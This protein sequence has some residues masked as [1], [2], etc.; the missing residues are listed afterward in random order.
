VPTPVRLALAL[1]STTGLG[2]LASRV[3]FVDAPHGRAAAALGVGLG[4]LLG[5]GA[6]ALP[7]V[8]IGV[9]LVGL[10]LGQAWIDAAGFALLS[11][12]ALW[13]V[14]RFLRPLTEAPALLASESDVGR[15]VLGLMVLFPVLAAIAAWL[16]ALSMGD[17][18][19]GMHGF[20]ETLA[21][22]A[23]SSALL[24]PWPPLLLRQARVRPPAS[25]VSAALV[26]LLLALPV[27]FARPEG[28]LQR[29]WFVTFLPFAWLAYRHG[30]LGGLFASLVLG[31]V[32]AV[33][34]QQ[35]LG[36]FAGMGQDVSLVLAAFA[37]VICSVSALM[38]VNLRTERLS[39]LAARAEASRRLA[40]AYRLARF[41]TWEHD[42][43]GDAWWWSDESFH[44]LGL[45]PKD[46]G[47]SRDLYL[48][49]LHPDD[50][51]RAFEAGRA[52]IHEGAPYDLEI[53]VV[54]KTGSIRWIHLVGEVL[55]DESGKPH[56]FA[57]AVQDV[58]RRHEESARA[59]SSQK[60]DALGTL[61]AG[62][63][64]D[65]NNI[66]LA[67]RSH[68][69]LLSQSLVGQR[70]T[71]DSL[72]QILSSTERASRLVQQILTFGRGEDVAQ[73]GVV[74]ARDPLR[75]SADFLRA[76]LPTTV[77]LRTR[78]PAA[79]L[80]VRADA[81]Q[82]ERVIVNLVTNAYQAG[83]DNVAIDIHA[84]SVDVEPAAGLVAGIAPGHY[85]MIEVTDTGPGVPRDV[86]DR[87]FEPFFT[88]KPV[89]EGTGLGL[90]VV[91]GIIEAHGGRILVKS[92]HGDGTTFEIYLPS[93]EGDH[94]REERAATEVSAR[95]DE[96]VLLVDDEVAVTRGTRR[97][98][99]R[100]GYKVEV[101]QDG[102]SALAL[103]LDDP[104][105]FDVVVTD[106]SM[107]GLTGTELARTLRKVRPELPII[108]TTGFDAS[109]TV[110]VEEDLFAVVLIKPFGGQELGAA[111]R[112]SVDAERERTVDNVT[113][114]T[115]A[116][117]E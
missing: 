9:F 51:Q 70:E 43:T 44:I 77:K 54:D 2:W 61:S 111:I 103:F 97:L 57:G 33:A 6:T 110:D 74:D 31:V 55:R 79:A 42:L 16:M 32:A 92:S 109:S 64:H 19:A 24:A 49:M 62:I 36:P 38:V 75:S 66:L 60:M 39:A 3:W 4:A 5:C 46:K 53:R 91:H 67:I 65:F 73:R 104:S 35:G 47:A 20:R 105:A 94:T 83:G 114:I 27:F 112:S 25:A 52:A 13:A 18:V 101:C 96:R 48:S 8:G 81:M 71:H 30:V 12:P 95:G 14:E 68:A 26:L 28:V 89:G 22:T 106:H 7:A 10:G 108:L 21:A 40:A 82:L 80:S 98:L 11:M 99:R 113:P 93:S 84:E 23:V 29:M 50:K 102:A 69:E 56:L 78:L 58:T 41:G 76:T 115:R 34:G 17:P 37:G 45:D 87:I 15:F 107:P 88:T 72:R 59:V 63:A 100:L 85:A 90:S 116:L 117:A 1:F 86:L